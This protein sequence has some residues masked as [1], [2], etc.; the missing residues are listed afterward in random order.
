MA[1]YWTMKNGEKIDVDKMSI[2]H[3]RNVLK[4]IIRNNS[5]QSS[6][7]APFSKEEMDALTGGD[8]VKDLEHCCDN[9]LWE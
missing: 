7:I 3:L 4:M 1:I 5:K 8:A 9:Y 2:N 6:G